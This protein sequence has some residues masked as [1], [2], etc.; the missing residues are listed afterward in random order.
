MIEEDYRQAVAVADASLAHLGNLSSLCDKLTAF[1]NAALIKAKALLQQIEEK[2]GKVSLE[3][4]LSSLKVAL[5]LDPENE[6]ARDIFEHMQNE[7]VHN[8]ET[9]TSAVPDDEE[10]ATRKHNHCEPL[11]VVIVGGGASGIGVGIVLVRIFKLSPE[12]VVILERGEV[13]ESFRQWPREMRFISPSFNQEGW[14]YS[15]DLNAVA[16]GTSPAYTLH[17]E[18]PTGKQYASYLQAI[19][20]EA[21]LNVRTQTEVIAVRPLSTGGGFEID[22]VRTGSTDD[23]CS[24]PVETLRSRYVIWA[25]GEYQYPRTAGPSLFP[26]AELCTHNSSVKSW[27]ELPGDN[28]VIIGGYESGMDAAFNLSLCGKKCSVIAS[29]AYWDVVTDDPSTELSP[30]TADR[31]RRAC[32]SS[33][34]PELIAP[35]RVVEVEQEVEGTYI[36]H[37]QRG[38]MTKKIEAKHR[39]QLPGT[40]K[41]DKEN[42]EPHIKLRT[43]QK[44]ILCAGFT[45]SVRLGVIKQL[46][47]WGKHE[48]DDEKNKNNA[49]ISKENDVCDHREYPPSKKIKKTVQHESIV[50]DKSSLENDKKAQIIGKEDSEYKVEKPVEN[51]NKKHQSGCADS[52]PLLNESDEST[53][54]PGLFLVGP[55]VRQENKSFCFVY[56]F[57]QRFA[58]VADA[59]ARGLGYDVSDAIE[60]CFEA[61][62]YLDDLSDCTSACSEKCKC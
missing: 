35:F 60:F 58:I 5:R 57:R 40:T 46:F 39:I 50:V 56:K 47:E 8:D 52:S 44:P 10:T 51:N 18:H 11:D 17:T 33:C 32:A 16:Y 7:T 29:T 21:G 19:N 43:S 27:A 13:G 12:R 34:P 2:D 4:I 48:N 49:T 37:A 42:A 36:V 28:F 14:T 59:I 1:S 3:S 6:E 41:P 26:G 15:F 22:V 23:M 38:S 30:Y 20:K 45:G 24:Q 9:T 54:T 61:N 31:I 25:A 55:A 53:K 62:M